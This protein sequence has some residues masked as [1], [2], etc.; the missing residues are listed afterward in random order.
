MKR[1]FFILA[2]VFILL[3]G[4]G[5]AT[6]L[7]VQPVE[8]ATSQDV[9]VSATPN[10]IDIANT[11]ATWDLNGITGDGTVDINTTYYSNPNGDTTPPSATVTDGE[12]RFTI[13]NSSGPNIDYTTVSGNFTGGDADM[14]NSDNGGAAVNAY[15]GYSWYSGMTYSS[16][17]LMKHT[18]SSALAENQSGASFKWG[19]EITTRTNAWTGSD[20]STMTM[21]ISA[22][23]A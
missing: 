12:C 13:T 5:S 20:A 22:A 14:V 8:A 15:G 6:Y 18:G 16:K 7:A 23:A 2:A 10:Y 4:I 3:G 11:P 9:T 1:I 21:T 19:A 17:V